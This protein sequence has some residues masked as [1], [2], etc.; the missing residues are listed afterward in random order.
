MMC[1][2]V[3][4]FLKCNP[5]NDPNRPSNPDLGTES[6]CPFLVL[7]L[8]MVFSSYMYF[9]A[10]FRMKFS[11]LIASISKAQLKSFSFVRMNSY[12]KI[13]IDFFLKDLGIR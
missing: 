7:V 3:D 2:P 10:D 6:F 13:A 11:K 1:V 9:Y 12:V 8:L 4:T 5:E